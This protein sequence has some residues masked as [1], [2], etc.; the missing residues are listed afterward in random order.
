MNSKSYRLT[1][2][3]EPSYAI[4]GKTPKGIP[5][6]ATKYQTYKSQGSAEIALETRN[7]WDATSKSLLRIQT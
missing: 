4:A 1:D 5:I 7:F 6:N 2:L 3:T